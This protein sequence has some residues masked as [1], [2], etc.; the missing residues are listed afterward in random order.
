[1]EDDVVLHTASNGTWGDKI[2][3]QVL[4]SV[5]LTSCATDVAPGVRRSLRLAKA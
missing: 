4:V 3:S 1:M 5:T 2:K